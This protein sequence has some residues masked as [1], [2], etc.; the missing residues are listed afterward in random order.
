MSKKSVLLNIPEELYEKLESSA[1]ENERSFTSEVIYRLKYSFR[2]V[3]VP[4]PPP[5]EPKVEEDENIPSIYR[6]QKS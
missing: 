3:F 4:S 5:V 1:C 6:K 2:D